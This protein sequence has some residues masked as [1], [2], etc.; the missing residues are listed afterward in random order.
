MR[1]FSRCS[2][3]ANP[4]RSRVPCSIARR[5]ICKSIITVVERYEA[6]EPAAP[7]ASEPE[8]VLASN[9]S[10]EALLATIELLP[11]RCREAFM[12]HK[13]DGLSHA[14]VAQRMGISRKM[15]E[16]HMALAL[17]ACRRC[18]DGLDGIPADTAAPPNRKNTRRE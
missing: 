14:E 12:L 4:C 16:Q 8:A 11:L 2:S 1:A 15:V 3:P 13:F 10:V 7:A 18:R 9:Q 5:A 17:Q 6:Q